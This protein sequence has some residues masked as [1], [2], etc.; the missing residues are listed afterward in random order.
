MLLTCFLS[1][2]V[3]ITAAAVLGSRQA[4]NIMTFTNASDHT[5]NSMAITPGTVNGVNT[6]GTF[7][8]NGNVNITLASPLETFT[9]D[10]ATNRTFANPECQICSYL[11]GQEIKIWDAFKPGS[12]E[13]FDTVLDFAEAVGAGWDGHR[14]CC[15]FDEPAEIVEIIDH[16]NVTKIISLHSSP[17]RSESTLMA[18]M[19]ASLDGFSRMIKR[20]S[21]FLDDFIQMER[22]CIPLTSVHPYA[23]PYHPLLV[24]IFFNHV[25]T[26]CIILIITFSLIDYR[27]LPSV[28][29]LAPLLLSL[30][31]LI[32]LE[33]VVQVDKHRVA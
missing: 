2:N 33:P 16:Y 1:L 19:Q 22:K 21:T 4:S 30:S 11:R 8:T 28:R 14:I 23:N 32:I 29:I 25:R 31:Y 17:S 9:N 26:N 18:D 13:S 6:T 12:N 27:R 10:K 5:T 20:A 7:L 15:N 24:C 3:A